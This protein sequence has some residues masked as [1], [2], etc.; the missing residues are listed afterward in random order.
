MRSIDEL[1]GRWA[2]D[3]I[4]ELRYW[5]GCGGIDSLKSI[6]LMNRLSEEW[7]FPGALPQTPGVGGP[8]ALRKRLKRRGDEMRRD[9]FCGDNNLVK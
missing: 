8:V 1:S 4:D 3:G 7:S 6:A 2:C 9:G 5:C